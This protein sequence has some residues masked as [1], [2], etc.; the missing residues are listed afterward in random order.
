MNGSVFPFF[1]CLSACLASAYSLDVSVLIIRCLVLVSQCIFVNTVPKIF[2]ISNLEKR[3]YKSRCPEFMW[4]E[5]QMTNYQQHAFLCMQTL[6]PYCE[7]GFPNL[8]DFNYWVGNVQLDKKCW[9]DWKYRILIFEYWNGISTYATKKYSK[10]RCKELTFL[11]KIKIIP[12][13]GI[14]YSFENDH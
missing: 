9:G 13:Q 6:R 4:Q 5:Q 12:N 11:D 14:F 7:P 10:D 3:K 1:F 2:A 8:G